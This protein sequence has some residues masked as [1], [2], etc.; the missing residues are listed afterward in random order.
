[1]AAATPNVLI[2]VM[3]LPDR[4]YG[5]NDQTLSLENFSHI[6]WDEAD[7]LLSMSFAD[8]IHNIHNL[9]LV[10][11]DVQHWFFS[12]QYLEEHATKAKSLIDDE[13][14]EIIFDMPDVNAAM[15]YARIRGLKAVY[16]NRCVYL[17][18]DFF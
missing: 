1:M 12:S 18:S 11:S 7:E 8:Q 6:V 10:T 9:A 2:D 4:R 16:W 5:T 13:H 14:I 3:I 15:R 17:R